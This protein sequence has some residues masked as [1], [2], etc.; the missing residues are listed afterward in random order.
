MTA[1]TAPAD[2]RAIEMLRGHQARIA[3]GAVQDDVPGFVLPPSLRASLAG[4]YRE[5]A[6]SWRAI[7][8]PEEAHRLELQASALEYGLALAA[9]GATP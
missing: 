8:R 3:A 7:G 5:A 2:I 4:V 6:L 1:R 9:S